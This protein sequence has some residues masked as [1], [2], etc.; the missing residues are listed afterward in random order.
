MLCLTT[1]H[2]LWLLIMLD[3]K[4]PFI[5]VA[6]LSVCLII[7][8]LFYDAIGFESSADLGFEGLTFI[9][10]AY[11]Y[12]TTYHSFKSYSFLV[13]GS[14]LLLFNKSYDLLTEF[15][16][17]EFYTDQYEVIDTLFDDGSLFAGFLFIAIGIT[18]MMQV[19]AKQS[20]KDDLTNL[21]NRR[22]FTEINL[23]TFDLIYFDLNN[24]KTVND[25]KGHQVGDLMIIRFAQVLR[26]ACIEQEMAFRVGGDE[27]V[28]LTHENRSSAFIE[29]M[30]KQLGNEH[31]TFAYGIETATKETLEEA[32]IRSDKSMYE[33]KKA[34]KK[35][36]KSA[37]NLH[38]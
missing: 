28:A 29:H 27:F 20:M 26:A 5:V 2:N 13:V 24:L 6:I 30:Y 38:G 22:K 19:L 34:Q 21:Y 18:H 17:I 33:M 35:S 15:P 37:P 3:K 11:I 7:C 16:Q 25:L 4:M 32:L 9:L 10:L 12:L 1:L 23:T 8:V 36:T 31:I 14:W